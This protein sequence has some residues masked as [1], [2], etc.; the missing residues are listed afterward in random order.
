[1]CSLM[2]IK[3][4]LHLIRVFC[5][6]KGEQHSLS[7][8]ISQPR[9][10]FLYLL[11][12]LLSQLFEIDPFHMISRLSRMKMILPRPCTEFIQ[13]IVQVAVDQRFPLMEIQPD[14]ITTAAAVEIKIG[15]REDLIARHDMSA[16]GT[17][18]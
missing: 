8:V 11:I 12:I 3:D 18:L 14:A 7:S 1:M 16:G 9:S 10:D 2:K 15:I 17:E 13:V 5:L 4:A 6:Q